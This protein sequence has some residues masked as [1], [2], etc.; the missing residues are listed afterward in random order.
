[1][2]LLW[3]LTCHCAV[4]YCVSVTKKLVYSHPEAQAD[5]CRK[6]GGVIAC[7]DSLHQ[8]TCDRD[9]TF[10]LTVEIKVQTEK[11]IYI[12]ISM[13][14]CCKTRTQCPMTVAVNT[15]QYLCHLMN[16]SG[17]RRNSRLS[18]FCLF[19]TC[20]LRKSPQKRGEEEGVAGGKITNENKRDGER[21]RLRDRKRRWTRRVSARRLWD[22]RG[23]GSCGSGINLHAVNK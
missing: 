19:G 2:G 14:T 15:F 9:F 8:K 20:N 17:I 4:C 21:L 22:V 11:Y 7:T 16:S 6:G 12:Y 23:N 13:N 10:K 1:M 5:K 18:F 3:C